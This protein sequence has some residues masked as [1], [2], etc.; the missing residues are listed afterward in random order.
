[1]F[2]IPQPCLGERDGCNGQIR[3]EAIAEVLLST[4]EA[5]QCVRRSLP[6]TAG[7]W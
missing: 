7:G 4:R 3:E 5:G 6:G 2:T 1:M